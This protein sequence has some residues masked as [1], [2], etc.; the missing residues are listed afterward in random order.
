MAMPVALQRVIAG[1]AIVPASALAL[2][3]TAGFLDDKIDENFLLPIAAGGTVAVGAG[4]GAVLPHAF[5]STGSHLR[6]AAIGA[7]AALGV[8][9]LSTAALFWALGDR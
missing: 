8:T 9:A 1:T 5:T 7:G 2:P 3:I 6:G 4:V